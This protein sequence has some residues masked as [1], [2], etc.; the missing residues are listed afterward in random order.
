MEHSNILSNWI[1]KINETQGVTEVN[2]FFTELC[3][4]AK[5]DPKLRDLEIMVLFNDLAYI[6][7][8]D[9]LRNC[10]LQLYTLNV[11]MNLRELDEAQE[12][13]SPPRL[14]CSL[15]QSEKSIELT[16]TECE[17]G[18]QFN[19]LLSENESFSFG[20]NSCGIFMNSPLML[21]FT[22]IE[23][24][25]MINTDS[26][27]LVQVT[28][29]ELCR[30]QH[31]VIKNHNLLI[32][33]CTLEE[34]EFFFDSKLCTVY[35][36]INLN[37]PPYSIGFDVIINVLCGAL[38]IQSQN[39]QNSEIWLDTS[40]IRSTESQIFVPDDS[41]IHFCNNTYKIRYSYA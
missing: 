16:L 23:N 32:K 20:S 28:T 39:L 12:Y 36:P 6:T 17:S 41:L 25:I 40:S 4:K 35:L 34:I 24:L 5:N 8:P 19:K 15:L 33:S 38:V 2:S 7:N 18:K 14:D 26:S 1:E 37:L 29:M 9:S 13:N 10:L 11:A 3:K 21:N 22:N 27:A 31:F 30:S